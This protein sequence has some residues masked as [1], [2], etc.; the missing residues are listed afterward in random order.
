VLDAREHPVMR[1]RN[2]PDDAAAEC[3]GLY[4][5]VAAC[6]GQGAIAIECTPR[7]A[8]ICLAEFVIL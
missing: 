1:G 7:P 8:V 6:A 2:V 5:E 4:T 3:Y